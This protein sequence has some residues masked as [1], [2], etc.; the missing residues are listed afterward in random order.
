MGSLS[1]W[2]KVERGKWKEEGGRRK[3]EGGRKGHKK[4][5]IV[6]RQPIF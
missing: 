4:K 2:W 6:S 1:L 3:V 5:L